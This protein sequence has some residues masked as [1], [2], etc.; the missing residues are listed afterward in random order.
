MKKSDREGFLL[1]LLAALFAVQLGFIGWSI[2]ICK[3]SLESCPRLGDRM[4][5][6]FMVTLATTL[7][8]LTFN[9]NNSIKDTRED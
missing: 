7:S 4:E 8:L 9:N 5:N 6:Y 2:G 3:N 1:K